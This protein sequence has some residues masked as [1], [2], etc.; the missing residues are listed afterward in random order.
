M[1]SPFLT[2]ERFPTQSA[3]PSHAMTVQGAV[4]KSIF[5]VSLTFGVA[6]FSYQQPL[7]TWAL[8]VSLIVSFGLAWGTA[9]RPTA[10]PITTPIYALAEGILLGT[11]SAQYQQDYPGI[12][13]PAILMTFGTLFGMLALYRMGV[14]RLTQTLNTFLF[15]A[16]AG[17][18]LTYLLSM[19]L[20]FFSIK[21]PFIHSNGTMAILF[22]GFV[23][24]VATLGFIRDFA[25]I[26]AGEKES[27]PAY[28]E[29]FSA[30]GLLVSL[31]WLYLEILRLMAKLRG[32]D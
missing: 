25:V 2:N 24:V 7:P 19:L 18:S 4:N 12:V 29:W 16:T 6:M 21:V 9:L 1:S 5:L 14:L 28:M 23:I 17:I 20:G 15:V 31:V 3:S 30:F 27:A 22:S 8:F 10:A 26:E 13:L 32:R 11:I